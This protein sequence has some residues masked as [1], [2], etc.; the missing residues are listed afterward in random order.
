MSK[1]EVVGEI[2]YKNGTV[3]P[4]IIV[5]EADNRD[6]AKFLIRHGVL[7]KPSGSE[8]KF[9]LRTLTRIE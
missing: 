4:L 3:Q 1:F 2:K 9:N 5:I 7:N 6:D 8:V